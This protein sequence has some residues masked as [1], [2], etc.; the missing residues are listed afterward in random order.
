[1]P[2]W[3]EVHGIKACRES[4]LVHP[5]I[6]TGIV[7]TIKHDMNAS[8]IGELHESELRSVDDKLRDILAL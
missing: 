4:G 2:I 5:S 3:V 1:M 7:K 6:V 8:K